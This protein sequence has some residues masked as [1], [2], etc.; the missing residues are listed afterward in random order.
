MCAIIK[1][2]KS[3]TNLE[4]CENKLKRL[5]CFGSYLQHDMY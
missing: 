1:E 5:W 3:F 2:K 4:H